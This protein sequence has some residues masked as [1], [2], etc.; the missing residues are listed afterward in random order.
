MKFGQSSGT[1]GS[2]SHGGVGKAP[3]IVHVRHFHC[4]S[5][6]ILG[7]RENHRC[8]DD[9]DGDDDEQLDESESV[10]PAGAGWMGWK[11]HDVEAFFERVLQD[12][13]GEP[14]WVPGA[15]NK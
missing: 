6:D 15:E 9:D 3:Q 1:V 5:A 7:H 12:P 8:Q 13:P 2:G 10:R 14:G 4:R 11:L